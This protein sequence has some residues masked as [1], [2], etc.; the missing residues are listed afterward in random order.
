MSDPTLKKSSV[1]IH[2]KASDG[3][4]STFDTYSGPRAANGV[5]RPVE[6]L[7]VGLEELAR[8]TALY[9]FEAEALE[10]FN[11]AQAAVAEWKKSRA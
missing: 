4:A 7:M 3:Y 6:A 5:E 8:L 2:H 1:S 11:N 9:G 10:R